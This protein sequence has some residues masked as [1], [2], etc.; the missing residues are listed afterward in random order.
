MADPRKWSTRL[1]QTSEPSRMSECCWSIF[2]YPVAAAIAKSDVDGTNALFN[3]CCFSPCSATQFI[4]YEYGIAGVCGDDMCY[5]ILCP[6]CTVRRGVTEARLRNGTPPHG[7]MYGYNRN[8]WAHSLFDCSCCE[9][10][11]ACL[12]PCSVA[13]AIHVGLQP[14][15]DSCCF[16]MLCTPATAWYG[17]TRHM[18]GIATDVP[19]VEDTCLPIVCFPCALNRARKQTMVPLP[20]CA[21]V[22]KAAELPGYR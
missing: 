2:C 11:S 17:Q 18:Y 20:R 22:P 6:C 10:C 21:P 13:H 14:A 12:C 9:M 8:E 19:C 3:C 15:H 1:A 5:G 16:D 4:R 7:G